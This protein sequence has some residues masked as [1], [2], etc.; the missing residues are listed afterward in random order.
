[1]S[2]LLRWDTAL[3][4]SWRAVPL[5]A[6]ATYEVS[7]VDKVAEE[8]EIPVRLCNYVDVYK[9]E[10]IDLRLEFMRATAT[11]GEIRKFGL[12]VDDVIITKDSES[13][14]DIAVPALVTETAGDGRTT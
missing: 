8:G 4:S 9:N 3:P 6:V 2:E 12:Q 5:K 10:F 11:E 7:N 14:D 1:V 13:W